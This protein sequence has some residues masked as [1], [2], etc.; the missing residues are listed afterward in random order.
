MVW[1]NSDTRFDRRRPQMVSNEHSR[2]EW[3]P[4]AS[5]QRRE[6]K[7]RIFGERRV[8]PPFL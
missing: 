5:L 1:L 4:P 7:V 8:I 3:Y 2:G 6:N